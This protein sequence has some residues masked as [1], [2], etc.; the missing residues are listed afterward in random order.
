MINII[1]IAGGVGSRLFPYSTP[2]QPKQFLDPLDL[3]EPLITT[4]FKRFAQAFPQ[5]THYTICPVE[6]FKYYEGEKLPISLIPEKVRNKNTAPAIALS[7]R[8]LRSFG[9]PEDDIVVF[10]PADAFVFLP[11]ESDLT[12]HSVDLICA[13]RE[14]AASEDIVC[15]GVKPTF[16]S[17]DYG[18]IKVGSELRD[19]SGELRYTK[20][21]DRFVEKP[22]NLTA[23]EYVASGEYLW[24]AGIFIAKWKTFYDA[25]IKHAPDILDLAGT[26]ECTKIS[27]DYA[28]LEKASNLQVLPVQWDWTDL[29]SFNAIAAATKKMTLDQKRLIY[30]M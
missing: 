4:T 30:Q 24:N 28:V 10:T 29:G 25:L 5:G 7:I 13:V 20:R 6:Y 9:R 22:D 15:I 14:A 8:A 3:G 23:S 17:V 2:E 16:G 27:F 18:Y 26:E 11:S 12:R 21:I 1:Q 19:D